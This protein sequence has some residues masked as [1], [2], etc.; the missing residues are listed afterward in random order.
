MEN[1]AA[2]ETNFVNL[3]YNSRISTRTISIYVCN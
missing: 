1:D 2:L 3:D